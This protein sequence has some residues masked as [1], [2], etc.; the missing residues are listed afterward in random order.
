MRNLVYTY[1]LITILFSASTLADNK[2]V[3]VIE[4]NEVEWGHLNPLRGELSPGAANLWGNRAED[5][6][7]GM[8]VRFNNGFQSPPHIHNISYRGIVIEGQLHNDDPKAEKMWLPTGS[9]WTQPAGQNH[10]TAA[11]SETNLIYLEIDSGPYLVKPSSE[12]FDNGEHPINL[13]ID[14]LV[15]MEHKQLGFIDAEGVRTAFVWGEPS[16]LS[17]SMLKIPSGFKG[18]IKTEASEF[19]SVIITGVVNY[20]DGEQNK[21]TLNAG[22][23]IESSGLNTHVIENKSNKEAIIYL[24]TDGPYRVY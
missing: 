13:H 24:R 20:S 1:T 10:I 14:N 16:K 9:F 17:G 7:T 18:A 22:S 6:A 21:T 19:R 2:T 11:N 15:W 3:K 8:L 23:Y 4:S 5:S 12:K